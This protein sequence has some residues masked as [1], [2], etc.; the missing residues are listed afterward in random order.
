MDTQT[1]GFSHAEDFHFI[2]FILLSHQGNYLGGT[3]IE[4][5]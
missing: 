1:F 3:D 2:K 4:S 5:D